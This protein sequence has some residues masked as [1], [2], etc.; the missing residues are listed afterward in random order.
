MGALLSR[1]P[2]APGEDWGAARMYR[3]ECIM[4]TGD[5]LMRVRERLGSWVAAMPYGLIAAGAVL[6]IAPHPANFAPIGAMALFGGAALAGAWAFAVPV[7]ALLLSDVI[8]GFYPGWIWV[9]GS[10]LL[11]VLIGRALRVRRTMLRVVVAALGSS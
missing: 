5:R 3:R 8:L 7:A 2:V 11:I 9:Y 6:R 1:A 4:E 10:F